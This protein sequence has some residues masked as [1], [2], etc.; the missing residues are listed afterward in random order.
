MLR[1]G[2][3]DC[4]PRFPANGFV[5]V[6]TCDGEGESAA[7]ASIPRR[8]STSSLFLISSICQSTVRGL[9]ERSAPISRLVFP[10]ATKAAISAWRMVSF[11][12]SGTS[13]SLVRERGA[14]RA[15]AKVEA[16][17]R[18][19]IVPARS[20]PTHCLLRHS[21]VSCRHRAQPRHSEAV[22]GEEIAYPSLRKNGAISDDRF[23]RRAVLVT[24]PATG[25]LRPLCS[26]AR[27]AVSDERTHLPPAVKALHNRPRSWT[28]SF[29]A[30]RFAGLVATTAAAFVSMRQRR[31]SRSRCAK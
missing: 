11:G 3:E 1:V 14:T 2:A 8:F 4:S 7:S 10:F 15:R 5:R 18:T 13:A 31:Q 12:P 9:I 28:N 26:A 23:V 25:L 27:A 19:V 21:S 30:V 6:N 17:R 20:R 24:A 29:K 16:V 22:A